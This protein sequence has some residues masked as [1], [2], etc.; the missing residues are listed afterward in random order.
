VTR[1]RA[2]CSRVV[3]RRREHA[4]VSVHRA[5]GRVVTR[6]ANA[7]ICT[8]PP[9][10]L[11]AGNA[12]VVRGMAAEVAHGQTAVVDLVQSADTVDGDGL[13]ALLELIAAVRRADGRV[14]IAARGN[15]ARRLRFV[16]V[17]RLAPVCDSAA[18]A[19][20]AVKPR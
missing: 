2:E 3:A 5:A 7:V 18:L 8:V 16:G 9:T 10:G 13:A 11:V 4:I 17:E 1:S 20:V 6:T 15:L 14:A 19:L 12:E